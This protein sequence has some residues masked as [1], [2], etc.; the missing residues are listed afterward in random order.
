MITGPVGPQEQATLGESWDA[1]RARVNA[2]L[3]QLVA[4]NELLQKIYQ[5]VAGGTED[6]ERGLREGHRDHERRV[7]V[8]ETR[9]N[10]HAERIR[11]LEQAPGREAIQER[12]EGIQHR[13]AT[14]Q[15]SIG[16][17]V[18]VIGTAILTAIATAWAIAKSRLLAGGHH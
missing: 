13:R 6:D 5:A 7:G 4:G 10:D 3:A 2:T 1:W 8:L 17:I 16:A 11:A 15:H 12:Q 9:A 18:G 14:W